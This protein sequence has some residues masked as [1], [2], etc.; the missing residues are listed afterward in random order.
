M[1]VS[2]MTI[3][4]HSK[5]RHKMFRVSNVDFRKTE[6]RW[7]FTVFVMVGYVQFHRLA[8]FS[9]IGFYYFLSHI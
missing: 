8:S 2:F 3:E 4:V 5:Y 7:S 6:S 9:M 1:M